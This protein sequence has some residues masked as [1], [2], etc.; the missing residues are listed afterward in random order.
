MYLWTIRPVYITGLKT[1]IE[2]ETKQPN[3]TTKPNVYEQNYTST[4]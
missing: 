1:N 3:Q 4:A 2:P